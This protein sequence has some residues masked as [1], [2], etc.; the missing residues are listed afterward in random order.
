VAQSARVAAAAEARS[1]DRFEERSGMDAKLVLEQF[2][3]H[4]AP[5]LDTYEQAIYLYILRHSRLQDLEEVVI[6][7]KSARR[8]MAVGIGEKGKPMAE[9]T[10]YE[11]LRSLQAKGCIEVVSSEHD[12]TRIRLRLPNEINGLIP[13]APSPVSMNIENLDF[14]E[15]ESNRQA[16]LRREGGRCFYCMRSIDGATFVIEHVTSRPEGANSYRNVVAACRACNN[17][18]GAMPA[19]DFLRGLYREG[20]LSVEEC[21]ARVDALSRLQNGE[22]KPT[23]LGAIPGGSGLAV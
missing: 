1:L 4:L 15:V 3:D 8:R 16:I 18:K 19:T 14:F 20:L 10:C 7:F 9:R 17:R 2:H 6:G 23:L 21:Q 22:L 13:A 5:T 12:G 11:K